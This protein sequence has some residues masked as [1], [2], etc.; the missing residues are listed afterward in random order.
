[1]AKQFFSTP[2]YSVHHRRCAAHSV[3]NR[4]NRGARESALAM[5]KNRFTEMNFLRKT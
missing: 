4:S 5:T 1:M 2:S 3:S